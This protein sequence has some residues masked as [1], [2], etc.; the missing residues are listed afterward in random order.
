M[1]AR[2]RAQLGSC[3]AGALLALAACTSSTAGDGSTGLGAAPFPTSGST[4]STP[5]SSGGT[6][7]SPTSPAS[8]SSTATTSAAPSDAAHALFAKMTV[9]ERVGQLFMVD[10]PSTS[11]A[12]ATVQAI[13]NYHVGSVILDGNSYLS[14]AQTK[15][16]TTS[17]EN[18]NPS[19]AQLF[20]ATDQEGGLVQRLRGPGF[21][22]IP[23]AVDQVQS[24]P[25]RLQLD[26]TGWGQELHAAGVNVD[27]APVLDTVPSGIDNPPIGDLERQY[28]SD[29]TAV[30]TYGRAAL[31][32]L[33]AAGIDATV[34]HF[35][36][37]GRVT[38]NTDT[39][40]GV[41]D[42]VTARHDAYLAPFAAAVSDNVPFV[43]IATA[44]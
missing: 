3:L 18:A 26:W 1:T 27:L 34:K 24:T 32:G 25:A 11:V 37:L 33:A 42:S 38:G 2:T 29:P 7:S 20:V 13:Q 19:A 8:P 14:V 44:I 43:M 30:T 39:T 17:L 16:L 41:R 4:A 23:A 9:A 10:C 22:Q 15:A 12:D 36:G 6:V 31:D 35:P 28:G 5:S 40:S 21:S